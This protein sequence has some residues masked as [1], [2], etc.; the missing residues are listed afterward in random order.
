MNLRADT[1]EGG[2]PLARARPAGPA[3]PGRCHRTRQAAGASLTLAG[4]GVTRL[5]TRPRAPHSPIIREPFV[6]IEANTSPPRTRFNAPPPSSTRAPQRHHFLSKD[7]R[8]RA[9]QQRPAVRRPELQVGLAPALDVCC[10][11]AAARF[12]DRLQRQRA[13]TPPCPAC[14]NA[15]PI[16]PPPPPHTA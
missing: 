4:Q 12:E 13:L 15:T 14:A 3:S 7:L 16:T 10:T 11:C 2:T 6:V 1:I 5:L 9:R 8:R